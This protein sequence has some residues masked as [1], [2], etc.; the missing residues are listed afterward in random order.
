MLAQ[1]LNTYAHKQT[2][3]N[4]TAKAN[5][6][7]FNAT[8]AYV[9]HTVALMQ[10]QLHYAA[11]ANN[12]TRCTCTAHVCKCNTAHN[13]QY[14]I[15]NA[16]LVAQSKQKYAQTHTNFNLQNALTVLQAYK[17]ANVALVQH[18]A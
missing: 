1:L 15:N 13:L 8:K 10:L 2:Q 9:Q 18:A 7:K 4:S 3:H 14:A 12:T 17:R 16:I 5:Y 6:Y 11:Q